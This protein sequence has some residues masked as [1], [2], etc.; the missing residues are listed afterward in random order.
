M[1]L[2]DIG[3]IIRD[4]DKFA[5]IA[6]YSPDGDAIGST[7]GLFNALIEI[8][9]NVD[10]FIPDNLPQRF[11]YL[12]NYN[13]VKNIKTYS[14]N[15]E[16]IFVLDCG[17][18]DRLGEFIDILDKTSLIINIDH[19]ISNT[20]YGDINY[21]DTNAS[22]V[23]EIIYNL[24]KINGFEISQKTASCLYTSIVSDT[25]GFKYSNTT[26]MT[27]S[28]AGDLINTGIDFPEINRILF[29]T[30]T[31]SQV[32]LLSYV[33]STLEMYNNDKI[34][35][36]H[37]TQKM[38]KESGASEDD[39]QEM[40]NI[41]RDID[42]VEVGVFIKEVEINKFRVSLRSKNIVDVR[43]VAER[44]NGGGHVRA[45]GCTIEGSLDEVKGYVLEEILRQWK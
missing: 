32:K 40:V 18:K 12:P 15:Y 1:I 38:L 27:F 43:L 36:I 25:G 3:R 5:I 17:D 14:D 34:A 8:N 42:T 21:V 28:I 35:V 24:L 2:N 22:S 26:S 45:A 7:L 30:R 16:A 39:A 4:K 37:M 23:G 29:D 31:I 6:H 10:I 20:L 44:F 9:K 13:K 11:N 41:A 19:H 33:T